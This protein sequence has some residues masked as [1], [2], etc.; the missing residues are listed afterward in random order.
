MMSPIGIV[1]V[2][3]HSVTWLGGLPSC[4]RMLHIWLKSPFLVARSSVTNSKMSSER[5]KVSFKELATVMLAIA[6]SASCSG[7]EPLA[8]AHKLSKE[9]VR[10]GSYKS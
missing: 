2:P 9:L 10:V 8:N 3:E 1:S 4:L 7:R 5:S 6:D